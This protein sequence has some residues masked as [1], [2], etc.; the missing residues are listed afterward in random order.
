MI[1]R[2]I[3][4]QARK[5]AEQ[6][7]LEETCS[8]L[9]CLSLNSSARA[10]TLLAQRRVAAGGGAG[11][12]RAAAAARQSRVPAA[13]RREIWRIMQASPCALCLLLNLDPVPVGQNY[14]QSKGWC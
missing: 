4:P 13:E 1:L 9:R 2:R 6:L 14:T 7:H 5:E 11:A 10:A 8:W 12:G 3:N